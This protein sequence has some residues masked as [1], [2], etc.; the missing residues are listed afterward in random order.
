MTATCSMWEILRL[1]G[2]VPSSWAPIRLAL[3]EALLESGGRLSFAHDHIQIAVSDRYLAGNNELADDTQTAE[4]LKRRREV[5]ARLVSWF[6]AKRLNS[7]VAEELPYQWLK[8]QAWDRLKKSLTTREMFEMLY[9]EVVATKNCWV[10]GLSWRSKRVPTSKTHMK[11]SG[12]N[13]PQTRN[14]KTSQAWR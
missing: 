12:A 13:G 10:A 3:A 11:V 4:G 9:A 7:R 1:T 8:A 6:D 5:H 14:R 2:L